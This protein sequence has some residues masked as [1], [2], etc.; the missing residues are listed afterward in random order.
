V[1]WWCVAGGIEGV[2]ENTTRAAWQLMMILLTPDNNNKYPVTK[3]DN[4]GYRGEGL[5]L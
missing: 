2:Y 5:L 3:Q 1:Q 4:V